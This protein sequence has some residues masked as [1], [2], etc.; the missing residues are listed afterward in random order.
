MAEQVD[1]AGGFAAAWSVVIADNI[2]VVGGY[3]VNAAGDPDWLVRAY[4]LRTGALQW[5]DLVNFGGDDEVFE[6]AVHGNRV[7]ATGIGGD[8]SSIEIS[9]CDLII[10]AYDLQHGTLLWQARFDG[11]GADDGGASIVALDD[12]VFVG[13]FVGIVPG[14]FVTVFL[15][16]AYDAKNGRLIWQDQSDTLVGQGFAT[17]LAARSGRLFAVGTTNDDWRV[18][19]YDP[20]SGRML[21]EATYSLAG[22][23]PEVFDVAFEAA[24]DEQRVVVAGYGSHPGPNGVS[25]DWVVRAYD[26]KTGGVLWTDELDFAGR[27]DEAV[28]GVAID[29]VQ[30]FAYGLVRS[31]TTSNEGSRTAP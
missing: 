20:Q 11:V 25:R 17:K 8:C 1:F 14:D 9:N 29:A 23:I 15:V 31:P 5:E 10:R 22:S 30:V 24:V 2:A 16:Q 3:G 28:G 26:A 13:G 18:R 19:A 4:D 6:L 27:L 21:W 7:F 12:L